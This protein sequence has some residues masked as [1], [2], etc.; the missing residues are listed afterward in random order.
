ML[1]HY[2]NGEG[3]EAL[4]CTVDDYRKAIGFSGFGQM[5]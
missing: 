4:N 3:M 2:K 5:A 1:E